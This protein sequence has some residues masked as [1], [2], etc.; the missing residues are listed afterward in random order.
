MKN[1][2]ELSKEVRYIPKGDRSRSERQKEK[3][4]KKKTGKI[5]IRSY[6]TKGIHLIKIQTKSCL[7]VT[8]ALRINVT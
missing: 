7:A 3:Q 6:E 2:K 8:L 5:N 1:L 4:K